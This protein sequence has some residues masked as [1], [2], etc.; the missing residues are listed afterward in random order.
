[1]NFT[2]ALS[3]RLARVASVVRWAGIRHQLAAAGA[4]KAARIKTFTAPEELAQLYDL[5]E[6]LPAGSVVL[7]IGSYLGASACVIASALQSKHSKLLCVDTWH[8]ETMPEGIM[9]TRAIFLENTKAFRDLITPIQKR[10]AEI[11][12]ADLPAKIDLAFID[13]DHSYECAA[14][15]VAMVLPYMA[16]R[17]VIAFHDA[18]GECFPGVSRALGEL[19]ARGDYVLRGTV[20]SLA[21]AQRG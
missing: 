7:E 3:I 8:N 5:A 4:G 21:W 20:K 1:M 9:D 16:E 15:D 14:G 18:A 12:A 10:S 11:T 19:L 2:R 13:G 6:R 17:S